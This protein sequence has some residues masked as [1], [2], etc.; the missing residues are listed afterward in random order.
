MAAEGQTKATAWL[1][2]NFPGGTPAPDAPAAVVPPAVK[3]EAQ[4]VVAKPGMADKI[5]QDRE[6]RA[7]AGAAQNDAKKY[8]DEAATLRKEV[9]AL[10]ASQNI[11]DP[12]EFVRSRKLTKEQQALWGQAMLYDLKPEVA[13]QEFRLEIYKAQQAA[14]EAKAAEQAEQDRQSAAQRAQ[15][16]QLHGYVAELHQQIQSSPEGS[17]PESET[18]F[19]EDGA[20]GTSAVNREAYVQS[21]LATAKNL[22]ARGQAAGQQVDLT[23]ANV[24]RV[25]EA[26]VAKRMKRRDTKL[27]GSAKTQKQTA[28]ATPVPSD[29][30]VT[31]TTMSAE[32]LGGGGPRP[33]AGTEEERRARAAAALFGTK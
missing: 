26:E 14:K 30:Q 16:Q 32:G 9:E 33:P 4:T 24:A 23:P 19:T 21:L 8:Q 7:A 3:V 12:L 15:T 2:T 31:T 5:R 6:S 25:L 29:A 22:A 11:D 17:H 18:W 20:D 13:P 27:A 10:K 1:E 28:P